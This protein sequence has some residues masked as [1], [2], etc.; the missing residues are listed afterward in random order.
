ME[1]ENEKKENELSDLYYD[2]RNI[3]GEILSEYNLDEEEKRMIW[4]I[5]NSPVFQLSEKL[6]DFITNKKR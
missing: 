3:Y 2:L 6:R 4:L 1:K 5:L